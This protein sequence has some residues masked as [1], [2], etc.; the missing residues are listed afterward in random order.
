[1][2]ENDESEKAMTISWQN[3]FSQNSSDIRM[4]STSTLKLVRKVGDSKRDDT[5][6]HRAMKFQRRRREREVETL[7][8]V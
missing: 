3:E 7:V 1:M 6:W 8:G 2:K 5:R 4:V